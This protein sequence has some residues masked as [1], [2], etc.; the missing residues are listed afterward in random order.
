MDKDYLLQNVEGLTPANINSL[1]KEDEAEYKTKISADEIDR[2]LSIIHANFAGVEFQ[3]KDLAPLVQGLTA[4][5]IPSRL[6]R[7][8]ES[9]ELVDLGGSPKRYKTV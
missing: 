8:V 3:N 4:R 9:E 2:I 6:K 1:L 5:Q 7:L